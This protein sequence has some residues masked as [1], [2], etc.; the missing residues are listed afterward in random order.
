[1]VSDLSYIDCG[2]AN[3]D[4]ISVRKSLIFGARFMG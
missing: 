3:S 2:R 4:F 1:M